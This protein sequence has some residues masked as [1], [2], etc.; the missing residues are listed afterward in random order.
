[1]TYATVVIVVLAL[2]L[3]TPRKYTA[4]VGMLLDMAAQ[5]YMSGNYISNQ[6]EI[7][8]SDRVTERVIKLLGEARAA[9]ARERMSERDKRDEHAF[10]HAYSE[11]LRSNLKVTIA[12]N[13]SLMVLDFSANDPQLAADGAN[14]FARAYMDVVLDLRIEPERLSERWF[15]ERLNK[16]RTSIQQAK[17]KLSDYQRNKEMLAPDKRYDQEL[18]RLT[19]LNARLAEIQ[20]KRAEAGSRLQLASGG[21]TAESA[22]T[23]EIQALRGEISRASNRLTEM[24]QTTGEN[25]PPRRQLQASI[26]S[27]KSQ[28]RQKLDEEA[29][30][31]PAARETTSKMIREQ[32]AALSELIAEQQKKVLR[33]LPEHDEMAILMKDVETAESAYEA[34]ANRMTQR[35]LE[36]K[37]EHANVSLLTP[38]VF[39]SDV[40][41]ANFWKKI[42]IA[43]PA[44]LL[45]GLLAALLLEFLDRR[46]RSIEDLGETD[47]LPL[48]GLLRETPPQ[49]EWAR[50][51]PAA[52]YPALPFRR[53]EIQ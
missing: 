17:R 13:N 26:A 31:L 34:V 40:V 36:S 30:K 28:L 37:T 1:M 32:E 10:L 8:K 7:V 25:Y 14:A 4:S 6:V 22:N 21:I 39:P 33:L 44:G 42:L 29:R 47:H 49:R 51:L 43:H 2:V 38:A 27:L 9:A 20:E 41:Q 35:T 53:S 12:P 5:S 24:A 18:S 16:L 52:A 19:A 11:Q 45:L 48:L 23:P 50:L 3:L 46:I 15:D